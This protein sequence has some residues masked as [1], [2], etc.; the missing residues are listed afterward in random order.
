MNDELVKLIML[1]SPYEPTQC[2]KTNTLIYIH[3]QLGTAF[4]KIAAA[5]QHWQGLTG[6]Q[7]KGR[8]DV[9]CKQVPHSMLRRVG[10]VY[11]VAVQS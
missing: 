7:V 2:T 4:D 11:Y 5:W 8:F 3:G 6:A 10:H 9:L 1:M